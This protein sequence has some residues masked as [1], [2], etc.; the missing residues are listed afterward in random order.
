MSTTEQLN[1]PLTETSLTPK[2]RLDHLAI[3]VENME[4]TAGF[5]T[6]VLGLKRHPMVVEVSDD[7]PTCGGMEAVFVDG[8]GLW[9]EMIL[10]TTP[11]PGMDILEQVGDGAIV[12]INFEAVDTDYMAIIDDMALKG[13]QMVSMD[14]SPLKDGG[15]IDEGVRGMK[16]TQETGQ[17]IAYWPTALSGGTTIEV[18]EKI[19]AD[20]TN[21]L[22]VRD[23]MWESET[24]DLNS[25]RIDHVSILVEDLEKTA[26]FYTDTMGL[27]CHP[28][29]FRIQEDRK[30]VGGMRNTFIEANG[31]WVQLVQPTGPGPLMDL[32][33]DK[34]DGYAMEIAV[35]V[36]DLDA[37]YDRMQAKGVTMVNLNGSPLA[38]GTKGVRLENYGDRFHYF[39]L[40]VSRGLRVM[41]MERGPRKSSIF[42]R[43]DDTLMQ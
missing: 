20:E 23:K 2:L 36:G 19:L 1:S 24:A 39:P 25:P 42:H 32:L 14:G 38:S 35:E 34:G 31:V 7:D 5:L 21:L 26:N 29:T 28:L 16:E 17:R 15:R 22:N 33:K 27:K 41:V 18:Y 8:N 11:G 43:R 13:V 3:W 30:A 9:L 10:P 40:E 12:E 4:K 6:D 37:F